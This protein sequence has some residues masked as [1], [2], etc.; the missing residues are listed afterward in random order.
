[1]ARADIQ[2]I[3]AVLAAVVLGQQ[4]YAQSP[5]IT[6]DD[7]I[8]MVRA[9]LSTGVIRGTLDAAHVDFDLSPDGLIGLKAA[10]VD[11]STIETMQ[12]RARARATGSTTDGASRTGPE[13]SNLLAESHDPDLIR[14]HLKTVYIDASKAT[15]FGTAQMKAA[16]GSNRDWTA[17]GVVIVDD[18][19]V[20]DAILRVSHTFAW[21]FPF[22]LTHQNT[23][24]VLVSGT[25]VGPFSGPLGAISVAAELT[26]A[27]KP[28]RSRTAQ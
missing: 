26:R 18:A 17:L 23:S 6:N 2:F 14:R 21:D 3:V 8:R 19:V 27:L 15:Y 4:I 7:V 12:A 20:A 5:A 13:K 22:T 25:G 9:Q 16:L 1:M 10:G 28:Y 24:M 11:E